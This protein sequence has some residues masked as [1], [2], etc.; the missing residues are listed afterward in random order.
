[1]GGETYDEA[2]AAGEDDVG[3]CEGVVVVPR[4]EEEE[5]SRS[6]GAQGFWW[7]LCRSADSGML[8][9]FWMLGE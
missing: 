3:H 2:G 1:M 4:W 8:A 9:S 6:A 7:R 5:V